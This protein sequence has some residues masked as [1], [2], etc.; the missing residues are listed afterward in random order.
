MPMETLVSRVA[1]MPFIST[2]KA[3]V[4]WRCGPI[5]VPEATPIDTPALSPLVIGMLVP[6]LWLG[7]H[8]VMIVGTKPSAIGASAMLG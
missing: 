7:M 2:V 6:M 5:T 1:G 8:I 3:P 4:T